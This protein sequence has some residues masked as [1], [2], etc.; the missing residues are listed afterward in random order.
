MATVAPRKRHLTDVCIEEIPALVRGFIRDWCSDDKATE[1]Q[2]ERLDDYIKAGMQEEC[3]AS[4]VRYKW[5]R[6]GAFDEP[7][8]WKEWTD[9]MEKQ[10]ARKWRA[11]LKKKDAPPKPAK[12]V[13]RK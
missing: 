3:Q 5:F 7:G 4:E 9:M 2:L 8:S 10:Q 6:K 12:K 11:Y 1:E 13:K